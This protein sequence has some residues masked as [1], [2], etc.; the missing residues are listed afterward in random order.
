MGKGDPCGVL[1]PFSTA[2]G[3]MTQPYLPQHFFATLSLYLYSTSY[4]SFT[5]ISSRSH[6][7]KVDPH[8]TPQSTIPTPSTRPLPSPTA[9]RRLSTANVRTAHDGHGRDG[10]NGNDGD[11]N[12]GHGHA[13]GYG[14]ANGRSYSRCHARH[15]RY[16]MVQQS[17]WK[18]R[19]GHAGKRFASP[20]SAT[21]PLSLSPIVPPLLLAL[22]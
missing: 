14:N 7:P 13:D 21:I 11:A 20:S 2:S 5:L 8:L 17:A 16:G 15:A 6:H 22:V 9:L 12:D 1:V 4:H 10:S 3:Y 18:V 19:Q